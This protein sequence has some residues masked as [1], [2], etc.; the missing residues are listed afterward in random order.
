VINERNEHEI[1]LAVVESKSIE[2]T[3]PV[4]NCHPSAVSS[5]AS[6][7][8]WFLQQAPHLCKFHLCIWQIYA[9]A[10]FFCYT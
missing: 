9:A 5:L 6:S 2:A 10:D 8:F 4:R 3:L 1:N 7:T